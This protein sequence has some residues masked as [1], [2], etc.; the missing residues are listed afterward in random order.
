M[1]A[2]TKPSAV[3]TQNHSFARVHEPDGMHLLAVLPGVP[4]HA[5]LREASGILS[6]CED[7]LVEI[8]EGPDNKPYAAWQLV[9]L[10]KAIIDS[11]GCRESPEIEGV[12]S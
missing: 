11:I 9:R 6:S 12:R 4:V 7:L 3:M 1:Q 2:T 8:D 5:A 10:A